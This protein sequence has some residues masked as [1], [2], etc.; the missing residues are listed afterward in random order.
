[1]Q[2]EP[3]ETDT[4]YD[5]IMRALISSEEAITN[6]CADHFTANKPITTADMFGMGIARRSLA[7]SSGF[8]S[9]IEKRNSLCALPMVRMQLDTVLRL[10]AGFFAPDHR[11]FCNDVIAG[12]QIDKMKSDEGKPMKDGYLRDRVA[13][14][15]PWVVDVYK[16]TSGHIH[17]SERHIYEAF[18]P[19]EGRSMRMIIGPDDGDRKP[20]EYRE[21][22]RCLHHLNLIIDFALKDWFARMCPPG[23]RSPIP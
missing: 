7:M 19:G 15:N 13:R 12:K 4:T 2:Q 14:R 18:R 5:E 6:T 1:M 8:R 10:Y 20:D 3:L 23:S 9:M 17:F 22:M 21:P 11:Q 16:T